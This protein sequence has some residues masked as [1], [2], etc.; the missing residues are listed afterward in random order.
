MAA[1]SE[2]VADLLAVSSP[3]LLYITNFL[4]PLLFWR[5]NFLWLFFY[6]VLYY[7]KCIHIVHAEGVLGCR[8]IGLGWVSF[9]CGSTTSIVACGADGCGVSYIFLGYFILYFFF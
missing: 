1:Y 5:F 4:S 3:I 7:K 9:D 2:R 6:D 8:F